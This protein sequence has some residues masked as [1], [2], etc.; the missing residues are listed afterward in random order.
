MR[1]LPSLVLIALAGCAALPQPLARPERIDLLA[2]RL[3]VHFSDGSQCA[4]DIA[5]AP[6]GTLSG[7]A[8]AMDYAVTVHHPT[9][10]KG[11]EAVFEP[12]A[13]VRLTRRADGRVYDWQTPQGQEHAP[14]PNYGHIGG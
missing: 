1:L 2:N 9:W 8:V 13:S 14:A 10:V 7:C 6:S 3:T 11:A 5:N 4:A 12:Y